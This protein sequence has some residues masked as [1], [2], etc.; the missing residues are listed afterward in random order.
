MNIQQALQIIDEATEVA[1]QK[2][3]YSKKDISS[4]LVAQNVI[5]ETINELQKELKELKEDKS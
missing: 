1:T 3:V 2:G 4:I 5:T